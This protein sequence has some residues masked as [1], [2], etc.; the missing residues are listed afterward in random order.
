VADSDGPTIAALGA[1]FLTSLKPA[2]HIWKY[3]L[4]FMPGAQKTFRSG[5]FQMS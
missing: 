5:S 3:W 1:S 4:E 2:F